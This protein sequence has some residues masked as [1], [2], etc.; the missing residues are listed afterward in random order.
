MT[1]RD[2]ATRAARVAAL[3]AQVRTAEQ[4]LL[5]LLGDEVDA[6]VSPDGE[7]YLLS[8]A[9]E[10]LVERERTAREH[11]RR[12]L[13][14]LD[15]IPAHVALLDHDGVIIAVNAAWRR[16]AE[17]NHMQDPTY[18]IGQ[19]YLAVCGR[20]TGVAA[21]EASRVMAGV[22]QVL[23][24]ETTR[25]E[26]EYPCHSPTERRWFRVVATPST[27]S[28]GV[29]AVVMHVDATARYLA[30][31]ARQQ[32]EE[33]M[34][35]ASHLG[36]L[37]GWQV[38]KGAAH[39]IWSTGVCDLHEVPPGTTPTLD[40]AMGFYLPEYRPLVAAAMAQCLEHGEPF[41]L[42]AQI[43]TRNGL[44]RWV[45][46]IGTAE[47]DADGA[48]IGAIGA[49]Q[50]ITERRELEQQFLRAQRMESIGTL[51]GGVAHDLNNVLAPILLSISYLREAVQGAEAEATVETIEAMA[52]RGAD[53]IRQLLAFAR[54][55]EGQRIR[56]ALLDVVEEVLALM[57]ET[58]PKNISVSLEL[59]PDLPAILGDATQLHQ[60]LMNLVVN[61]RDAMPHGGTLALTV[62]E[63]VLIELARQSLDGV[64]PGHYVVL[65]VEDSGA[66]MPPEVLDRAFEP[67]FTTKGVGEGTG[68]GLPTS[69]SIVASH[70][71][72]MRIYSE[73]G[74]GTRVRV[75]LP[76][77]PHGD[78]AGDEDPVRVEL[79]RGE[80][81]LI[82]LVDDEAAIRAVAKKML[83]RFGYRVITAENGED[84]VRLFQEHRPDISLVVTDL[85]MP[86]MDGPT[87]INALRHL[88]PGVRVIAASGLAARGTAVPVSIDAPAAFLMKPYTAE[89]LL[90]AVGRVL[91]SSPRLV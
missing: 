45:R 9:R 77:K 38:R 78:S 31:E 30:D 24:G 18:G 85:V 91:G 61:A 42:E 69:L 28:E 50:N 17:T 12:Q 90:S 37:G 15:A 65:E 13:A 46:A 32:T 59:A 63:R 27:D 73:P 20:A 6:L 67:F 57:R 47:R 19:N 52:K 58:F 39:V 87:M 2:E 43:L 29:G 89:E 55:T 25:F 36:G 11:A 8:E 84:G 68:L 4:E 74:H 16:F 88:Q 23:G 7:T 14:F 75:Y 72:A 21:A 66:G 86:V 62:Q 41:D 49:V 5:A 33:L 70:G 79:P 10:R 56:V 3:L 51:A 81:Q 40:D 82:L 35:V 48:I 26:I 1:D 76:A 83:E 54:G 53:L 34:R 22:Q 44:R 64:A 71:G 60:V 80:G